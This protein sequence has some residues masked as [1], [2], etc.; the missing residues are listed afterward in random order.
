MRLFV[1]LAL[2][3]WY[4]KGV[5]EEERFSRYRV[6]ILGCLCTGDVETLRKQ[7]KSSIK[8]WWRDCDVFDT[9]N[10]IAELSHEVL[11]LNSCLSAI[12]QELS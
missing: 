6:I 9:C 1:F 3:R 5:E 7:Y 12:L 8:H 10:F 11:L 2:G 4:G